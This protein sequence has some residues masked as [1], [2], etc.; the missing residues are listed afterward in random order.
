MRKFFILLLLSAAAHA[1]SV[2]DIGTN[3]RLRGMSYSNADFG[4]TPNQDFSYYSQRAQAHIG[5]RFSPNIEMMLRLQAI[6]V[7][8]SSAT[9]LSPTVDATAGRYPNTHFTPWVQNAYF[10]VT[11][12]YDQPVDLTV[13]RQPMI[14]GDGLILADDDLGLTGLRLQSRLPFYGLSADAFTF[15]AGDSISGH[16]DKD[17][18]GLELTKPFRTLRIQT[19]WVMER[20]ASGSTLYIRPSENRWDTNRGFDAATDFRATKIT[21]NFFD[22]RAEG[23]LLEGGFYKAELALQRG[24]VDRSSA[25]LG[26]VDLGGYAFLVSGGLYTRFSKYGPIEIH[27]LFGQASGDSGGGTDS[28]FRPSFGHR[29]DGLERSGFGEFYGASLYDALPSA[30][31][32]AGAS[33][34]TTSGLPPGYSG[35][36]VIGAGLTAHPTALISIGFDYYVYDA[37]ESPGSNFPVTSS[38]SSLGTEMDIGIGFAYTNYLSFRAGASFFSPGKAY[39]TRDKAHRYMI[40][41]VGRF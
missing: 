4:A 20:D 30:R 11:R 38:E 29:F 26:S 16:A 14:L 22:I 9:A 17:I 10:K 25:T 35:I 34:P 36:R 23:R 21:R 28:S 37:Q 5:G 32:N 7:V 6:D 2:L 8:G 27:G 3:Y 12:L 40:E 24:S 31:Y 18:Y 15:K 39:A 33:S 1:G 19:S 41:A 13:G